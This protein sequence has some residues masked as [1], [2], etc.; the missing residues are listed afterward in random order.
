M[1]LRSPRHSRIILARA[2]AFLGGL[3][4]VALCAA[5]GASAGPSPRTALGDL[6]QMRAASGLPRVRSVQ[7]KWNKG[8]KLHNNY[9]RRTGEFS[10][11]Q[12]RSSRYYTRL[13]A[14]AAARSVIAQPSA[15]PTRAFGDTIYHRLA[16]LQPR[17]IRIGYSG[18]FGHTCLQVLSGVSNAASVRIRSAVAY[19][20]PANGQTGLDPTFSQNEWPDP[21]ADA[22]GATRLGT[23]IT[24]SVNG[25]WRNWKTAK[26]YVTSMSLV[27]ELGQSIPVS[28]SD[29]SS[30]NRAYLYGGFALLPRR[31][32]SK[33]TWYTA[34]ASGYVAYRGARYPVTAST[35]FK[36]GTGSW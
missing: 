30:R 36:T 9:M 7:R 15:L 18:Q 32:L 25:P 1:E 33:N 14:L 3:V 8:C 5:P 19:P 28:A 11:R 24:F 6:N 26:S 16:M 34:R 23:P 21:R 4:L 17:L 22:P 12:R 27:D 29:A 35:R 10:H 20:W 2:L 31:G 13:G